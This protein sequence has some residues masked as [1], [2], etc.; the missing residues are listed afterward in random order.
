MPKGLGFKIF[1]FGICVAVLVSVAGGLI[2]SGSP[3]QERSRQF[4]DGRS[5]NLQEIRFAIDAY[6]NVEGKFPDTL[7]ALA[8]KGGYPV[9]SITDQKTGEVYEYKKTGAENYELCAIFETDSSKNSSYGK[10]M[11]R[12]V[13]PYPG[14]PA[15]NFF[16]HGAGR[17]CFVLTAVKQPS[18]FPVKY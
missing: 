7:N 11:A 14:S 15:T 13:Y 6:F 5:A 17:Q 4:D 12:P 2:L 16:E 18:A 10:D 1:V 3:K 9:N 8:S